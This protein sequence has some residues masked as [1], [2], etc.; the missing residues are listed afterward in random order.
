MEIE[1]DIRSISPAALVKGTLISFLNHVRSAS[2]FLFGLLGPELVPLLFGL[3]ELIDIIME[4]FV[5]D[6]VVLDFG[7]HNLVE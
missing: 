1:R 3:I 7:D 2:D 4:L 6:G 5:V